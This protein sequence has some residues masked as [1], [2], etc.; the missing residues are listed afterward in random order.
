MNL[1]S[2]TEMHAQRIQRYKE[3][4]VVKNDYQCYLVDV[5]SGREENKLLFL[6]WYSRGINDTFTVIASAEISVCPQWNHTDSCPK[7]SFDNVKK[8]AGIFHIF[9][10]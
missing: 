5:I 3:N 7:C 4:S 1:K 8:G 9:P 6:A 2:H 10:E